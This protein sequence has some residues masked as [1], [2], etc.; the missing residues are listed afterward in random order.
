MRAIFQYH[1]PGVITISI[2]GLE[3]TIVEKPREAI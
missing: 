1:L 3:I 2:C